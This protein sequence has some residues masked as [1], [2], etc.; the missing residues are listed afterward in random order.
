MTDN[1]MRRQS[2]LDKITGAKRLLF[3]KE[4]V[5]LVSEY[6]NAAFCAVRLYFHVPFFVIQHIVGITRGAPDLCKALYCSVFIFS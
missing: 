4:S 6:N 2:E 5:F 3:F 1:E